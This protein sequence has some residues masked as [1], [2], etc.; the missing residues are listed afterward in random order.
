MND[1]ESNDKEQG[2][3]K[4]A[5]LEFVA[6][7]TLPDGRVI[8]RMVEADGG[9]PSPEEFDITDR[10]GFL[11]TFNRFEQGVIEARDRLCEGVEESLSQELKKTARRKK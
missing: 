5:R 6:R 9:I 11:A 7:I 3:A 1:K 4:G 8:E 2:T 10:D